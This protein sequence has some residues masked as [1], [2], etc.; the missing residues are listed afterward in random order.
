MAMSA[1]GISDELLK[2]CV[3]GQPRSPYFGH[4]FEEAAKLVEAERGALHERPEER[5]LRSRGDPF[6]S[7]GEE[8]FSVIALAGGPVPLHGGFEIGRH[9]RIEAC[10]DPVPIDRPDAPAAPGRGRPFAPAL[11]LPRG[12]GLGKAVGD[13][14]WI[15]AAAREQRLPAAPRAGTA[16]IE[17]RRIAGVVAGEPLLFLDAG[18]AVEGPLGDR[19]FVPVRAHGQERQ[20]EARI[21]AV[22][23]EGGEENRE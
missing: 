21:E 16:A 1:V 12:L 4:R 7:G 23:I 20:G 13:Q 19:R 14:I 18:T 5:R 6:E 9:G 8:P 11:G 22:R 3:D 10:E 17:E 2:R 15:E